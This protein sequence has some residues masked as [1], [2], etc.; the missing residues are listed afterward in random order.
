MGSNIQTFYGFT[1]HQ[2]FTIPK[3]DYDYIIN[4]GRILLN[5]L[6]G[7]NS[8]VY[9]LHICKYDVVKE[10]KKRG[11]SGLKNRISDLSGQ[12]F[13]NQKNM[14]ERGMFFLSGTQM[15]DFFNGLNNQIEV[16]SSKYIVNFSVAGEYL[17]S[18]RSFQLYFAIAIHKSC[19]KKNLQLVIKPNP[20]KEYKERFEDTR[21]LENVNSKF[22]LWLDKNIQ[23]EISQ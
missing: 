3:K 18:A 8:K 21:K 7:E 15:D 22:T 11:V 10:S 16:R 13:V 23:L 12:I 19:N 9:D 17:D 14:H 1:V 5:E 6:L 4:E 2:S 20:N